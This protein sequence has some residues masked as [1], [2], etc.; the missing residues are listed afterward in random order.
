MIYGLLNI[1]FY[2][3]ETQP[4]NIWGGVYERQ[5]HSNH[6]DSISVSGII[7]QKYNSCET[8]SGFPPG[9]ALT[10]HA[11]SGP[12]HLTPGCWA[13]HNCPLSGRSESVSDLC[14]WGQSGPL[15]TYIKTA[16]QQ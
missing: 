4:I 1:T 13:L 12:A 11:S 7:N 3:I 10:P 6:L 8:L 5:K 14:N 9:F 2:F 15:D 16:E